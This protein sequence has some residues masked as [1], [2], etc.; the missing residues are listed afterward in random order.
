K[1]IARQRSWH[2]NTLGALSCS[3]FA[4]RREPF[5]GALIDVPLLS[6][7]NSYRPPKGVSAEEVAQWC[8]DELEREILKLGP[9]RVAAFIF[10]PVVGAAGLCGAGA[11]DLRSPWRRDDRR[12][13]DVRQRALRHLA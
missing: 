12:R 10:E 2:G 1:I 11:G 4:E 3:G 6:P 9:Q 7:V 8:A 5:E 13:D